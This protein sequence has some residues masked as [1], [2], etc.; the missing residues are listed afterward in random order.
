MENLEYIIENMLPCKMEEIWK[1]CLHK[2]KR[3]PYVVEEAGFNSLLLSC[4]YDF[5][6]KNEKYESFAVSEAIV[7]RSG[8]TKGR[9]DIIWYI[10]DEAYYLELKGACF[11]S[12]S[13][14][15][16]I[17][18][19]LNSICHAKE[20]VKS[21]DYSQNEKW[22]NFNPAK[23]YGCCLSTIHSI[24]H[25]E[26]T[27]FEEIS[28]IISEKVESEERYRGLKVFKSKYF[29]SNEY[30]I[31]YDGSE[32]YKNDGFFIIGQIFGIDEIKI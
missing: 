25:D 31:I 13:V 21:I 9:C 18:N 1:A 7:I 30:P 17:K 15:T 8:G 28:Q 22:Y 10:D 19:S 29:K 32:P 3:I 14:K 4:I 16:D 12:N 6:S 24:T 11:G 27:T 5:V 20:Q 2:N 23:R 26:R